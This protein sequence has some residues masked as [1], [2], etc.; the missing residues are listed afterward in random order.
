[1]NPLHQSSTADVSGLQMENNL[2]IHENRLL[3]ARLTDA[4]RLMRQLRGADTDGG[5]TLADLR[6][7][8]EDMRHLVKRLNNSGM[9]PLLRRKAGFRT[10]VERYGRG[11]T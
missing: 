10:L 3:R 6:Q 7:A 9:G 11:T 4:E 1:M 5:P 2:L 8:H